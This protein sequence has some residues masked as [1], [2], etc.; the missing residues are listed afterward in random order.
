MLSPVRALPDSRHAGLRERLGSRF[1]EVDVVFD[2]CVD[3]AL[4][5]LSPAGLLQWLDLAAWLGRLGRGPEPLLAA[6]QAWPAVA[7]A[8]GEG[9]LPALR[10]ALEDLQ[11]S[12]NGRA[13]APL[14]LHLPAAA[15]GLG[16]AEALARYLALLQDLAQR[17]SLSVHG[18]HATEPSSALPALMPVAP[19]LLQRIPLDGL[20]RWLA[21][22]LRLHGHHPQRLAAYCAARSEDSQALWRREQPGHWLGDQERRLRLSVQALFG[23]QPRLQGYPVDEADAALQPHW[24]DE[25]EGQVACC[26]PERL[27]DLPQAPALLR[28][29]AMLAHLALHRQHSQPLV[30]DNWSPL[31]R[32]AV[33]CFEDARIDHLLLRRYPGLAPLLRGLHPLPAAPPAGAPPRNRLRQRLALLSHALLHPDLPCHDALRQGFRDRFLRVLAEGPACT[34]AMAELALDW[35]TETREPSDQFADVAFEQTQVDWR[36]DNRH[37]WTF[38]EAGDEEAAF[39][40]PP[41]QRDAAPP[42]L[43]PRLYP[44]WDQTAQTLR[45]QWVSVYDSLQPAAD[46]ALIDQLLLRHQA[47]ARQLQ[48]LLDALKPQDR[49]RLRQQLDGPELDL[50]AALRA[51]T[52]LRAGLLPDPRVHQ[53][54][55]P[56]ARNLSVLLLLDL[57]ASVN[58]AVPGCEG[59]TVLSLSRAA[60]ALLADAMQRLGDDFA[61][62]GFHSN[63]RHELR[64]WHILGFGEDWQGRAPRARLAGIRGAYSTRL[65]AA[66]RH[67]GELLV[68]RSADQ[69]LLLLLTDGEPADI[70]VPEAGHLDFDAAHA[71]RGLRDQGLHCHAVSLDAGADRSMQRIFGKQFAVIDQ[72]AQLPRRLSELFVTLTR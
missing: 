69:R 29:R 60:V 16:T 42:G 72:V 26:L 55:R 56:R 8:V 31:Q 21:T 71:V 67:G 13:L 22:G 63:G 35:V 27:L 62:A 59:E 61:I 50:D 9:A 45:P 24:V 12:P 28:W 30:A 54:H 33:E 53:R 41:R 65:G 32:L 11:R 38:I 19:T 20:A 48:Q 58:D 7:Q 66:L 34:R 1:A 52:E 70:D 57:S 49:Q 23:Q 51:A 39:D 18:H 68:G 25:G 43:P 6:L 15:Q 17:T 47:T 36:D 3:Q 44:E 14:L 4:P 10:Q 37:L 2:D 64:F 40:E 5:L 46:P